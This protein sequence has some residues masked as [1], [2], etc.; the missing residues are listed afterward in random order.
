MLTTN[1]LEL[2]NQTVLKGTIHNISSRS[3]NLAYRSKFKINLNVLK[4]EKNIN[5]KINNILSFDIF[6]ICMYKSFHDL[7]IN[8]CLLTLKQDNCKN[9]K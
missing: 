6:Y 1:Y 3:L 9:N 5:I 4:A 2:F 8:K 7:R